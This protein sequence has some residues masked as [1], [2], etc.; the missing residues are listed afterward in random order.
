MLDLKFL[1]EN[2]ELVKE[3]TKKKGMKFNFD[4][5]MKLD[6]KRRDFIV[7]LDRKKHLRNVKSKE[8][9][10]LKREKKD[11]SHIL[12]E[13]KVCSAEI[14]E[15]EHQLRKVEE[16]FKSW[17]LW[18]PNLIHSSVRVGKSPEDN[19][20]VKEWGEKKA[21]SFTPRPHW[22]LEERYN[23]VSFEK[24]AKIVGAN[25]P[26]YQ[27]IG[28]KLERA[29]INFMLDLHTKKHG[30]TEV[31]PPFLANRKSMVGTGQ[32]PKLEEDMYKCDLDDLFPIPT[33]EVPLTNLHQEEI[34][35]EKSLPLYYTAYSACFRREA[36][37]Y[38]QETKG[39]MRVH[40]FNKV[41]LVKFVLPETSFEEL[42]SLL[43]DAEEVLQ[44]LGLPYRVVSL[45]SADL[46]FASAKTYDLEVWCPGIKKYLEV[47]SCSN[48]T[49]FQARRAG[50]RLKREE[51]S[52]LEYVHTLN[53]S[54]L[55]TP[56]TFIALIENYQQQDGTIVIPEVLRKYL[57]GREKIG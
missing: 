18:I 28:A 3:N 34:L 11:V 2:I 56:R 33:A 29:L 43:Q 9:A 40:Q 15:L 12:E 53:G 16:Q 37:S 55:A 57:D 49:D 30:Y 26:L 23:L 14:K 8:I 25:F 7:S 42:E 1:R 27:G 4:Q 54:G 10:R 51:K 32:L 39:L 50:I 6:Q 35:E 36:G 47:S 21:F 17:L 38:G 41:E 22:E 24:G 52:G 46:S 5:F 48:F 31:F 45:C 44:L 13:M 19:V 20:V